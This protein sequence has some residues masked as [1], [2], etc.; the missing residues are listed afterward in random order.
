L[1]HVLEGL[2]D[3]HLLPIEP[4]VATAVLVPVVIFG[5]AMVVRRIRR[6]HAVHD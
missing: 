2:H 1:M 3:V 6:Q 4:G 5:V